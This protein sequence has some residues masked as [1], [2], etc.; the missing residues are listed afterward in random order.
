MKQLLLFLILF[1]CI[2][3]FAPNKEFPSWNAY[4][5]EVR[6]AQMEEFLFWER[7]RVIESLEF[8]PELLMEYL[9]RLKV[10]SPKIVFKQAVLETG[11]FTSEVFRNNNN[12]FGMNHPGTRPS[13]SKFKGPKG[14]AYFSDWRD[15]VK[16]YALWQEYKSQWYDQ[17]DYY[18]FLQNVGYATD[19]N[20]TNK[21]QSKNLTN[22]AEKVFSSVSIPQE[23]NF[24]K[25]ITF[26][27]AYPELNTKDILQ[28]EVYVNDLNLLHEAKLII[29]KVQR[30][31]LII[32]DGVVGFIQ[33]RNE[34]VF[35]HFK[36]GPIENITQRV[37]LQKLFDHYEI[38]KVNEDNV[39]FDFAGIV[40]M[41]HDGLRSG[42]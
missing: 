31:A 35:V 26:P 18:G 34:Q 33:K 10:K 14:F 16:D 4:Q 2:S 11:W 20:Y 19:P 29:D 8:T 23:Y 21:L 9:V 41:H 1:P 28:C 6:Q 13:L 38:F 42:I 30:K 37:K 25:K 12:L 24:Q 7:D 27:M 17:K 22:M 3:L 39:Q 36:N 32:K 40:N 5:M 15:A